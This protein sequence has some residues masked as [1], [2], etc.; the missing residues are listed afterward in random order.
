MNNENNQERVCTKCNRVL[1]VDNFRLKKARNKPYISC[2]C[3]ECEKEYARKYRERKPKDIKINNNTETTYKREY[4][5]IDKARILSIPDIGLPL[6]GTDEIFVKIMDAKKFFISNYGRCIQIMPSGKYRLLEGQGTGRDFR[7]TVMLSKF[8]DGEFRN[9]QKQLY[10]AQTVINEFIVNPDKSHNTFIWH[11]GFDSD[12]NYYRNLYPVNEKQYYAIRKH[13]KATGDDSEETITKICSDFMYIDDDY[14]KKDSVPTVAGVGYHGCSDYDSE[15]RSYKVWSS[16]LQRCYNSNVQK[17]APAYADCTVCPEWHNYANFRKWW[18]E[19]YYETGIERMELDHNILAKGNDEYGPSTAAIVPHLIN[20]LVTY[21][22]S[23][24]IGLPIGVYKDGDRYRAESNYLG[25][26]KKLG[27][28]KTAAEAGEAYVQYKE[29]LI[30][31]MA[32][33]YH[34]TIQYSV[35]ESLINWKIY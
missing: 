27:T 9:V 25:Q 13:F 20:C 30:K 16:M 28:F 19:H 7:Y 1:S 8:I 22:K 4:K 24:N 12:D 3:K 32:G 26:T 5:R 34:K 35:Y 11:A 6:V 33:K 31:K 23:N 17:I 2:T 15:S 10:V 21:E 29:D 14:R 18:D